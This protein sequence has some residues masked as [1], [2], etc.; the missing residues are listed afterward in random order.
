MITQT[1]G[2][3]STYQKVS[4]D[5]NLIYSNTG[6]AIFFQAIATN[7]NVC[8]TTIPLPDKYFVVVGGGGYTVCSPHPRAVHHIRLFQVPQILTTSDSMTTNL[9]LSS[10]IVSSPQILTTSD[11]IAGRLLK[12]KFEDNI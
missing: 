12:Q 4:D 2:F 1:I 9:D 11:S 10:S 6:S 7:L 5:K 3:V 8:G